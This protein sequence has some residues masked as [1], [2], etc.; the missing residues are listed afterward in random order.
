[1]VNLHVNKI[2]PFKYNEQK[3]TENDNITVWFEMGYGFFFIEIDTKVI[4]IFSHNRS[5]LFQ[6]SITYNNSFYMS[7]DQLRIF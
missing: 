6:I 4:D 5:I 7:L 3:I 1:M 2:Y